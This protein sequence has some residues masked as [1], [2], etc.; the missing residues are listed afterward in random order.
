[1][2]RTLCGRFIR[3]R[4]PSRAGDVLRTE[5]GMVSRPDRRY[6]ESII[7]TLRTICWKT[8]G[9]GIMFKRSRL[10]VNRVLENARKLRKS[11]WARSWD[12]IRMTCELSSQVTGHAFSCA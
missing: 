1:M 5:T 3:V 8:A 11:A 4:I 12:A 7:A 10:Q 6:R 2:E 9:G